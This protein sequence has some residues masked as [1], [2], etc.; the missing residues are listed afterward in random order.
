M[1]VDLDLVR[2]RAALGHRALAPLAPLLDALS[3]DGI[4][5]VESIDRVL[6]PLSGVRFTEQL[7]RR[8]RREPFAIERS[9]DG[10]IADRGEVPT[11]PGSLHD[12]MNAVAWA[13]FPRT[14]QAIHH[15]QAAA[16]RS[17]IA[18]G[19]P[20][21]PGRRSRLRDRLSMLDEGGVIAIGDASLEPILMRADLAA[22]ATL[23]D[24]GAL[25]AVALGHAI[26][27]QL[28]RDPTMS[29]RACV[30]RVPPG[31][32]PDVALAARLHELDDAALQQWIGALPSIA[33]DAL[34]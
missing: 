7:P 20:S 6:G 21:L 28:V 13:A 30:V 26:T 3:S 18:D 25:R 19:A 23:R 16:L 1:A 24:R 9:Y 2:L 34:L 33:I 10:S 12:L 17:E 31:Q 27:E 8:R 14:K 11:R 29:V 4:P 5:T 22:L 32:P 15:R